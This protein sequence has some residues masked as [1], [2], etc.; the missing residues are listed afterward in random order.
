MKHAAASFLAVSLLVA[1]CSSTRKPA[2]ASIPPASASAPLTLLG[3]ERLLV[4]VN[5]TPPLPKVQATLSFVE[6]NRVAGNGQY[7]SSRPCR[8]WGIRLFA[9]K[10]AKAFL[11][12]SDYASS[13]PHSR[14]FLSSCHSLSVRSRAKYLQPVEP[15]RDRPTRRSPQGTL[16]RKDSS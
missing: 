16:E 11:R 9:L 3:T 14:C 7:F 8:H 2:A 1:S 13:L 4:D 5:G 12:S 15:F 10:Y 6:A